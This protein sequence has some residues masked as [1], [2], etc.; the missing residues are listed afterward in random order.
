VLGRVCGDSDALVAALD[1][2]AHPQRLGAAERRLREHTEALDLDAEVAALPA[3]P[4]H[5]DARPLAAPDLQ[6]AERH[7]VAHQVAHQTVGIR[8][9]QRVAVAVAIDRATPGSRAAGGCYAGSP[10]R[11][12]P[13]RGPLLRLLGDQL[14]LLTI[15]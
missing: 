10:G 6:I 13:S 9:L 14:R 4:R 5:V 15:S 11:A 3:L 8:G 1:D 7:P 2:L 12:P